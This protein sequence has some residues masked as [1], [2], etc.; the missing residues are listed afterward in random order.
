[1]ITTFPCKDCVNREMGCHTYCEKYK[2]CR[3]KR[4]KE[5]DE[6]KQK[7]KMLYHCFSSKTE[8]VLESKGYL[9]G[10]YY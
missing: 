2:E 3:E 7:R 4:A 1:M 9:R 6:M 5:D 8:K 10:R